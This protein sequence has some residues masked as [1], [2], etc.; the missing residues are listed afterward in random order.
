VFSRGGTLRRKLVL[1][2]AILESTGETSAVVDTPDEGTASRFVLEAFVRCV[3]FP[4]VVLLAA[5]WLGPRHLLARI[6]HVRAE[7]SS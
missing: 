5:V 1:L 6:E 4:A 7:E 3:S 2:L